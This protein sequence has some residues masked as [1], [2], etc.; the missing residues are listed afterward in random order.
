[1]IVVITE[2]AEADL[3]EIGD[4]IA[5]DNPARAL[6]F[7]QELRRRCESLIDGPR[8]YS[9]VPR[10]EHLGIRRR[11]YRNYLIFYRI[12]ADRIEILHVLH[13]AREYKSILFPE[14]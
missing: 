12:F 6:R 10:Y 11:V 14:Q 1:M 2:A 3:Q 8:H 9:R 7:V 5:R 4:W 13:G